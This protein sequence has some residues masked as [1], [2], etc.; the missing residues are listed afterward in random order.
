MKYPILVI[1]DDQFMR[2]LTINTLKDKYEVLSAQ[3]LNEAKAILK[4]QFVKLVLTDLNLDQENTFDF[5]VKLRNT[6]HYSDIPILVY[7]GQFDLAQKGELLNNGIA[8]FIEK[9]VSLKELQIRIDNT[10]DHYS[11]VK[12]IKLSKEDI[13][14][15]PEEKTNPITGKGSVFKK[16]FYNILFT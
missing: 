9:P 3:T 8:G 13:V 6:P 15:L 11:K 1:E 2:D 4:S 5:I 10:I 16:S 7:S 14:P 12:R